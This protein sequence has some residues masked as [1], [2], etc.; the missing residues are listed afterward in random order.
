MGKKTRNREIIA[1]LNGASNQGICQFVKDKKLIRNGPPLC[2]NTKCIGYGKRK[3]TWCERQSTADGF[4]WR[5]TLCGTHKSI[6]D[7][8][9]FQSFRLKISA[10]HLLIYYWCLLTLSHETIGELVGCSRNTVGTVFQRLCTICSRVNK[11]E[12]IQLGAGSSRRD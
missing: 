12:K 4:S 7:G 9:F 2:E 6:K 3:A 11:K 5:C 8:S 1:K 10:I